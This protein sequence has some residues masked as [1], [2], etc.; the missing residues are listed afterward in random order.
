MTTLTIIDPQ[1]EE[2]FTASPMT[3]EE[4]LAARSAWRNSYADLSKNIRE[5]KLAMKESQRADD[6]KAS[7]LQMKREILRD[8]ARSAIE[9]RRQMKLIAAASYEH[10]RKV[11]LAA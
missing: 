5:T 7:T 8:Y 4:Y 1:T 9:E 2:T 11:S 6:P 3:R 10:F